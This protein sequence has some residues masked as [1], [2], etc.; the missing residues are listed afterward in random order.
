MK[1]T[2]ASNA[3]DAAPRWVG[4]VVLVS[5]GF[6]SNYERGFCNGLVTWC[7]D[8]TLL[9]SDRTDARALDPRV[10]LVNL[11]GSQD[12]GRSRFEKAAN[13][14]KYLMQLLVFAAR[15][16]NASFHVIGLVEPP[17]LYGLCVGLYLRVVARRYVLTVHNLLPHNRH[18]P[19]NRRVFRWV[20]GVPHH[21][22]C[23]TALMK[24]RLSQEFGVPSSR[25]TVMEHGIEPLDAPPP[26]VP[27]SHLRLLFFGSISAYKGLDLLLD[28]LR[29][30]QCPFRLSIRGQAGSTQYAQYI[31]DLLASHPAAGRIDW[32]RGFVAEAEVPEMFASTD[33][34]VLPY[35]TIDQSG[36]LFQALRH[37]VPVVATDVGSFGDYVT[38]EVGLICAPDA[39]ALAVAIETLAARIGTLDR[40]GIR[41]LGRRFDWA[42]TTR[43][44]HGAYGEPCPKS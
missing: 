6:Q 2:D 18:T 34:L 27:V 1:V 37:G 9:G 32:R 10:Q 24:R 5:N 29:N 40:A 23:H 39:H 8:V 17:L 33:A 35:R 42:R 30:V 13:L 43:V 36:V 25:I 14:L 12:E 16:R 22:V 41:L 26:H 19:T 3:A 15:H 44:L 4:P 11:R 28:A 31:E 38:P 20:F 21:L 7:E